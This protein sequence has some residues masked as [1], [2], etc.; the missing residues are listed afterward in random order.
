MMR[1]TL[2][3]LALIAMAA[4][5][6]VSASDPAPAS[7]NIRYVDYHPDAIVRLT[8]HTGYQMMLEFEPG[9]RIETV[10]IG[11][12]SGWQVT[13]NGAG[14][15]MFLKPVGI[16]RT[17]NLS[18]VT[19]RRRYNIELA[20]RSGLKVPQSQIIYAVRF[21]YPAKAVAEVAQPAAPPLITTPPEQWNRAYSYDGAVGAVPE[22][23]FDDGKATYFRFAAGAPA[24]AI[25]SITPDAGESIVNFAVRGPY[26]VVEQVAPQF[27]LRSGKDVTFIFND[28]YQAPVPGADAPKRREK[29]KKRGL[30][31]S[32][33]GGPAKDQS[34]VLALAAT[35]AGGQP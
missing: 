24:P 26:M 6:A 10:G 27:V 17:T 18:I 12:S 32:L 1:T 20:A 31:G 2:L 30:F 35:P 33:F 29:K 19:S 7:P 9:E 15:V 28:A 34:A 5:A 22:Q 25:F 14:T 16:P 11:D 23:V 13:P 3:P 4:P 21:R 8:G